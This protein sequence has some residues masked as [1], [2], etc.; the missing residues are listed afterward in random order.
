[1]M[2]AMDA[3]AQVE[4][5]QRILQAAGAL[6]RARA[7]KAYLKSELDFSGV[8]IPFL[9]STAKS[10][11]RT[12]Q[13]LSRELL[14]DLVEALWQTRS[15]DL[16]SLGIALLELYVGSLEPE[17]MALVERLLRRSATW[18]HVD[19]LSTKVAAALVERYPQV[20]DVLESW[21]QEPDH[22]PRA[23]FWLRRA[24]M[25]SLLPALRA[26]RGDFELFAS[27]ASAMR[28]EKEFFIRKAIGWV[29]RDTSKKRPQL[30]YDFLDR[31]LPAISG[32]TLREGSKYLPK[33]QRRDLLAGYRA[34]GR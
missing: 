11:R 6:E 3:I 20:R 29:L 4:S 8:T 31:H 9:R 24:A 30:T 7:Q 25:L 16:R 33:E 23:G 18:D 34:R 10:F 21:S 5:F 27:F 2:P 17:D 1:M 12:H 32:L 15:H 26:G 19:W 13:D 14:I 28:E 22:E